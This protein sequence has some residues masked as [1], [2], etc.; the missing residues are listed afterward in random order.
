MFGTSGIRGTVG[1]EVTASVALDVGRAV[2]SEGA[3]RVVIGRDPRSTG[4]AL[5]DAA[6][7]GLRECGADAVSL[8]EV[9]TPTVA[10]AVEWYGA[11]AG[12]AVTASH[13]PASDNGLKLWTDDGAAY[14]GTAQDAVAERIREN[15]FDLVG[16]NEY[17][18]RM[19]SRRARSRHVDAV[20]DAVD[21]DIGLDV[22][23]DVG[24]GSGRITATILRDLGCTVR[25][26]AAE[27]DGSFPS[28]PSEPTADN[29]GTLREVVAATDADLGIAHDGDADRMRA[30]TGSGEFPS[31]DVLL[32]LFAR[33]I[34]AAGDRVAVPIDT[35]IAVDTTL[36]AI[37]ASTVH[38]RVGDG[39]VAERTRET[40]VVFGGEP[41][42]AWI[43]P[44]LAR[45]PDGPL[46][47]A[48]LAELVAR[49]GP[50]DDLA[51]QVETVPLRRANIETDAKHDL[52]AHVADRVA[53]R[54]ANVSTVDGVRVDVDAGWFLVRASGTQPLV[55]V[56]AEAGIE[57][58]MESLFETATDLVRE[59]KRAV[60]APASD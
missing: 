59:A 22:V 40:D 41:S 50:L 20:V 34:A 23:L 19:R 1:E 7:A 28:R 49:R 24:N 9:P 21:G 29:C 53:D 60:A 12:I 56:T 48:K 47:A 42:G 18:S 38:T 52:V 33:D 25:T 43:W 10:R 5:V 27:P 44:E 2:A 57:S 4:P 8:G 35:S 54:Y 32:A 16:W 13:N 26:L 58:E 15:A 31:G 45:C 46:A 51:A 55:R 36:E 39:Y 37:G 6:T 30:A 17:G 3:R 14:V 11:D